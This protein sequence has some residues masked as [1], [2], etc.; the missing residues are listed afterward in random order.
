MRPSPEFSDDVRLSGG[1]R[2]NPRRPRS[3]GPLDAE[4]LAWCRSHGVALAADPLQGGW[5]V[6]DCPDDLDE[7]PVAAPVQARPVPAMAGLAL[8][9]WASGDV[10]AFRALLDDPRVWRHL[11]EAYPDP[12]TEDLAA[13]LIALA[14]AAP[15][16][17]VWAVTAGGVPVG[18]V[19]IAFVPG[20]GERREAELSYWLGV[21]HWGR[22]IGSAA[23]ALGVE[24]AF[25]RHPG[26]VALVARVH[27]DNGAS[28]RVLEKAGFLRVGQAADA[29]WIDVYRLTKG[30]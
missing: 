13:E 4:E 19:R 29:P 9:P 1:R 15:H 7:P 22:G 5:V 20:S 25:R 26:L 14:N 23:V 28:A 10:P 27:R 8:R 6:A 21:G 17:V 12:L 11:P 18:Q 16:H 3:E 30:G 24:A 2:F